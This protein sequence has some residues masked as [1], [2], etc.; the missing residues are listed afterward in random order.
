[1]ID[2]SVHIGS[3]ALQNPVMTASGTFGYAD[4]FKEICD[5]ND[6]GAIITKTVTPHPRP[7]NPPRRIVELPY[8]MLNSIGL[9]N[10]GVESFIIEKMPFLQTLKTNVIINVAGT[11]EEGFVF[12]VQRLE[13]VSGIAGYELNFSCPNVKGGTSFSSDPGI[14]ERVTRNVRKTTRRPIIAKLT[15][16]VTS[17]SE[18]GRACENGG[19]DAVSAI[20][21]V[22]GMAIDIKT[23]RPRLSTGTGGYSGPA[24]KPIALAKV[25]ELSRCLSIPVIAIGGIACA[26]DAI[27]FLIAGATAFQ[28]GTVNFYEP[29]ATMTIKKGLEYYCQ[30]NNI[31]KIADLIGSIQLKEMAK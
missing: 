28:V 12:C 18:I 9:P 4:E 1:M 17:I 10:V 26:E 5:L 29:D 31:Q 22:V 24:I 25:F 14:A 7:G 19:A 16:N 21:T 30:K 3:L 27:E 13:D 20:N 6:I 11:D 8:G 23:R 15:P 2:L